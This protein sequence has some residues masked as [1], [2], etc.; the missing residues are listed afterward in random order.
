MEPLG[1]GAPGSPG[2]P[3]TPWQGSHLAGATRFWRSAGS[4]SAGNNQK[5]LHIR[6]SSITVS[7]HIIQRQTKQSLI[8][9]WESARFPFS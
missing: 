6:T 5:T 4:W 2:G 3:F 8:G 1:P 9:I 7:D